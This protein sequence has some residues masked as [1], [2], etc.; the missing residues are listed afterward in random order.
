M[1]DPGAVILLLLDLA[2]ALLAARVAVLG[3]QASSLTGLAHFRAFLTA[4]GLL[5]AAFF[6]RV[7]ATLFEL[8]SGAV[9]FLPLGGARW[10]I[11]LMMYQVLTLVGSLVL[12]GSYRKQQH[13]P[14]EPAA[15]L[16]LGFVLLLGPLQRGLP[17]TPMRESLLVPRAVSLTLELVILVVLFYLLVHAWANAHARQSRGAR[18]VTWGFAL[19]LASHLLLLLAPRQMFGAPTVLFDLLQLAAFALFGSVTRLPRRSTA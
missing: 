3:H 6:V 5:S 18:L 13:A 11:G 17:D 9:V 4:F 7:V 16:G 1:V 19:L 15:A 14:V 10:P 8:R 12:V 2:C